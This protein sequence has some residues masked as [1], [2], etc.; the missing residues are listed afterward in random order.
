MPKPAARDLVE[1]D[2]HDELRFQGLPLRRTFCRPPAWPAWRI[3]CEARRPDEL[4]EPRGQRFFFLL[5]KCRCEAD[6]IEKAFV[7]VEA[8]QKRADKFTALR[9]AKPSDNEVRG[10]PK[11]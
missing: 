1:T 3:A 10:A 11:R 8:E 4:F 7:I 2:L 5:G 9:I 6:M